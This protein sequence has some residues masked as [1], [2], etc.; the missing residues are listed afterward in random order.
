MHTRRKRRPSIGRRRRPQHSLKNAAQTY[1]AETN[2]YQTLASVSDW[3]PPMIDT[4]ELFSGSSK[5]TIMARRCGPNPLQPFDV[6][7]GPQQDLKDP[8]V[9]AEVVKAAKKFK[10]WFLIM[11]LDCRLWNLFNVNLNYSQRLDLLQELQ[12]DE[13]PLVET[14]MPIGPSSD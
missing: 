9:R 7:H 2:I 4:F 3:P 13:L 8:H 1:E 6:E 11:G 10:P 14:R 12:E 5:F